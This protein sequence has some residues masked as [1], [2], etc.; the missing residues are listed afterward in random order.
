MRGEIMNRLNPFPMVSACCG[1]AALV[2]V[3]PAQRGDTKQDPTRTDRNAPH[4]A[5]HFVALDDMLGADV[6]MRANAEERREAREEG[7]KP[8]GDKGE[9]EDLVVGSDGVI[10]WAILDVGGFLGIG[11]K[12]VAVPIAAL[13][14]R[15]KGTHEATVTVAATEK[16]LKA[17]KEFD[18]DE[19]EKGDLAAALRASEASWKASG[20]P[21]EGALK[22]DGTDGNDT[23]ITRRDG[24]EVRKDT[25][26]GTDHAEG[27]PMPA[28]GGEPK[29]VVRASKIDDWKV[30]AS[31]GDLGSI[32]KVFVAVDEHPCVGCVVVKVDTPGIGSTEFLVPYRALTRSKHDDDW[33][34]TVAKTKAEVQSGVKYTKPAQGVFDADS[35]HRADEF[36]GVRHDG[37]DDDHTGTKRDGTLGGRKDGGNGR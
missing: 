22:R 20:L 28:T 1:L 34:W 8:K 35:W 5:V 15:P 33:V 2:A 21:A 37:V 25:S 26:G 13:D 9:I 3:L 24:H 23:G 31:D 30:R 29:A 14:C 7:E 18:V 11:E 17:L 12:S 16:Q 6:V 36:F 10:R 4:P 32:S 27:R 19:A